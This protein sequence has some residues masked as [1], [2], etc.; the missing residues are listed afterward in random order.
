MISA[1]GCAANTGAGEGGNDEAVATTDSTSEA[2]SVYQWSGDYQAGN[3]HSYYDA[4]IGSITSGN[5]ELTVM[6]HT[7][8]DDNTDYKMF[9]SYSTDGVNWSVDQQIPDM[10]SSGTVR[11][12]TF[13][14]YLYMIHNGA[15]DIESV[16]MSRF[17][18]ASKTWGHD[19]QLPYRTW[20]VPSMAAY[21][22]S[23]YIIGNSYPT[24][25]VWQAKMSTAEVF[26]AQ[27]DLPGI[28]SVGGSPSLTVHCPSGFCF[29]ATLYMAYRSN[30]GDLTM[31]GL[32]F[33]P[34]RRGGT[35]TWWTPWVVANPDGSHKKTS[36]APALASYGGYLHIIDKLPTTS[37]LIEWTYYDGS[38]WS[39]EVSIGS[40]RMWGSASLSARSNRLVMVHSESADDHNHNTGNFS[41]PIYSESFQ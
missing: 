36:T 28:V 30:T 18:F 6:V 29:P 5:T 4:A 15:D 34:G 25:Q 9:Y 7:G 24:G 35:P 23:L 40:Q 22:G 11:M 21:N 38:N 16:W 37:D 26:S 8:A 17:N 2:L 14:G 31:S 12:A 27:A 33:L 19:Y 41:Y 39:P 1:L 13:N 10:Y 3:N 20:Y 32:Q